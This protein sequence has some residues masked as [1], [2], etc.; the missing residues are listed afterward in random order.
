VV[1][2]E[3]L[4]KAKAM[5]IKNGVNNLKEFGYEDVTEENIFTDAIYSKMFKRMLESNQGE[6]DMIDTIID[7][8]LT[9]IV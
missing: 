8:I 2:K 1:N 9:K 3:L 7:E 5:I 4:T 6:E